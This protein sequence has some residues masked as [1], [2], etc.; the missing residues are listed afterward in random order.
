MALRLALGLPKWTPNIVLMKIA[1]Q[2]VLSEKIKRLA[3]QFFIRQLA[4]GVH[5]PIY[6][7]NC[8]PSIK[9][10]KRNEVML[11]NLFTELDT[12]TRL[13]QTIEIRSDGANFRSFPYLKVHR[14]FGAFYNPSAERN[15]RS[16]FRS[17]LY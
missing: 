11:A 14:P 12:S 13:N 17:F 2:K 6:D 8:K 9:L 4:I 3:A 10:I 16:E 7:Q 1:G 5:S 15:I